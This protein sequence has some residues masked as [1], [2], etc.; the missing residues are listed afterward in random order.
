MDNIKNS[1]DKLIENL[2]DFPSNH[3][4]DIV[5][6]G[7]LFNGSYLIGA[8]YY[9]KQLEEKKYIK[10]N[11]I[12]GCSIG[13]LI[14]LI[15]YTENY[16]LPDIIY[17]ITYRHF[18]KKLNV[19]IFTEIFDKIRPSLTNDVMRKINGKFFITYYNVK[20]NKQI[21]KNTYKDADELFEI[22]RRSCHCPYV[23]DNNFLYKDKYVDGFH[24]YIFKDDLT[25]TSRI[26][27]LNIHN[28]DKL[29][30]SISI[31]NEKTN[32]TRILCGILD[33]H[34]F[35]MTNNST[36]MCSYVNEWS[37]FEQMNSLAFIVILKMITYLIHKIYLLNDVIQ[38]S[39][40][41]NKSIKTSKKK[42]INEEPYHNFLHSLYVFILK[43][44]CI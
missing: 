29:T 16:S 5:F 36:S 18:K 10:I 8:L 21:V 14:S 20:Q 1:I 41:Y 35:F 9:L 2:I 38:K 19:N 7:G 42:Y 3:T 33:I 43:T 30:H 11:R 28:F 6:E 13:A 15:Y 4:L 22:I 44:Y 31:K 23:V 37:I 24:P 32:Y 12:S 40:K 27:Y 17:K 26:L 25:L 34:T 39:N